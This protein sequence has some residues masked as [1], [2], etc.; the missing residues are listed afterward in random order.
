ME[1][2]KD[3]SKFTTSGLYLV[4]LILVILVGQSLFF[5]LDLTSNGL[6]SLSKA[7]K[8]AVSTLNEPLTVN[9]FFSKNLPAPYNNL[10]RYLHDLMDEYAA[11][12]RKYLSYRFFNVSARE[13]ELSDEA[14]ENRKMAQDY[15]IYPVNVQTIEQDEA[16][17]QRAYMGMVFI[18]GDIVERIPAITSTEGLEYQITSTIQKMNN[19][20]SALLNLPA[21]I[22]V[23][24]VQSSSLE[25]IAPQLGLEG[26]EGLRDR[27]AEVVNAQNSKTYGQLEFVS[28]DPSRQQIPEQELAPYRRF[29]LQWPE[30]TRPDGSVVP[31]GSGYLGLGMEF[32]NKSV[33]IQL[34]SSSLNLTNQ[35]LQEQFA[36]VDITQ[37]E[38]FI[39]ENV[40]NL[41]DIHE[42]IGYL[43][44]H[45]TKALSA[46]LPPQLQMMQ[47]QVGSLTRFNA[48]LSDR[49]TVKQIDMAEDGIPESVDSLIIAGP[50]QDFSDWELFQ[51]D[52]FLMKGKSLA[53]FVDAFDE[54]RPQ[55]Q[56]QMYG[57]QQPVFL[58]LNT[59]LEKLLDHYGVSVRKSYVMDES[60]YVSRDQQM[61]E[62]PVY[63]APIIKNENINH[64]LSFLSNIKELI[65]YRVSPVEL[66][67][68]RL[69]ENGLNARRMI[70]TTPDAWE[71]AG[72]INLTPF[73]IRP[74][75]NPDEKSQQALA[76]LLEGE[77]PS[78][79]ADKPVPEKPEP[80]EESPEE[81]EEGETEGR[82]A[83]DKK[84][85]EDPP[86]VDS[87]VTGEADVIK[88]GQPG[89]IFVIGSSEILTDNILGE[90]GQSPNA[91][92]LLNTIDYLNDQEDMAVM[93]SKNQRFNPLK[94]TKAF[95]RTIVKVLNIAGVPALFILFGF[96]V[97]VRR[98]A[99]RRAIQAMFSGE[100]A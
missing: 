37:I 47:Q 69:D 91:V 63:F 61:G 19:K 67:D 98:K 30:I 51:I 60:C 24:L 54:I 70:S 18:H 40:D 16:K 44:T 45:G 26:L 33:E 74:P 97:W 21:K 48:L 83:P 90:Q 93:R 43:S 72:Q 82:Q 31:A 22:R 10:E 87:Q 56:Q 41:I 95:T 68:E 27:I 20:I 85:D 53:L 3:M 65:M 94:D 62:T 28:I 88:R 77:F 99:R 7:S 52:Q 71:M 38:S 4:V 49:Y 14:E 86:V 6:Y 64:R 23:K 57:M 9:V 42:E 75:M 11:H 39:E 50:K 55:Q 76:Y 5:R 2:K 17:V 81:V 73:M 89:R 96:Y 84:A 32:G 1:K 13:S 35:G 34:L 78:Y 80:E 29:G 12:A 59:G 100:K 58:P 66:D 79:F 92:F 46:S 25:Q 8:R 15:G 36:I